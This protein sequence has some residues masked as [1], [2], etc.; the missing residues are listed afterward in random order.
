MNFRNE[1][2]SEVG[3]ETA[4]NLMKKEMKAKGYDVI[5]P[6]FKYHLGV[7]WDKVIPQMIAVGNTIGLLHFIRFGR[8]WGLTLDK[9]KLLLQ[10][11]NYLAEQ[12]DLQSMETLE[13][14]IEWSKPDF[15]KTSYDA[16]SRT[17]FQEEV[18]AIGDAVQ[19]MKNRFG[20][21]N[22]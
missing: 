13:K 15:E 4:I 1:D 12:G 5:M 16:S 7:D 6:T 9:L 3:E 10:A 18:T 11:I 20:L 2:Y 17:R 14:I 19:R 21:T 8:P 22:Q